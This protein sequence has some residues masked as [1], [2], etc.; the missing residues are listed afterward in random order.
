MASSQTVRFT[1][2]GPC[3]R[4]EGAEVSDERM[5]GSEVRTLTLSGLEE[6][7]EYTAT[8]TAYYP[9]DTVS[10]T[11]TIATQPAGK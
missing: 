4:E 1:Y 2:V 9:S 11:I 10:G 6:G 8:V 7:S 5:V 3:Q